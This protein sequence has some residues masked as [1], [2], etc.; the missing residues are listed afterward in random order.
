MRKPLPTDRQNG[1]HKRDRVG[2]TMLLV[3]QETTVILR[4]EDL[5]SADVPP[6]T[7]CG[8]TGPQYRVAPASLDWESPTKSGEQDQ[9]PSSGEKP[10]PQ[11]T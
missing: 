3:N 5:Q 11:T 8:G 6:G 9:P 10:Q 2:R 1:A 7:F 4:P